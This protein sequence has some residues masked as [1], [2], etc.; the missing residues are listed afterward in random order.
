MSNYEMWIMACQ[1]KHVIQDPFFWRTLSS[2]P[3]N[4]EGVMD[5]MLWRRTSQG[6]IPSVSY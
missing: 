3:Y 5:H 4:K 6:F 2:V 1:V